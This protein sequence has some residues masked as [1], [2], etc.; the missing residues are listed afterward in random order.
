[1]APAVHAHL[2]MLYFETGN[3]DSGLSQFD[4]EKSLF[5]ESSS[6]IDFL[7]KSAKEAS[8]A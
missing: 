6:Y 1:M 4:R 8:D 3:P 5:P 7:I 2:G